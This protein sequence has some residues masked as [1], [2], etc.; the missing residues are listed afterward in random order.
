MISLS[1][2]AFVMFQVSQPPI[3]W[4]DEDA[5]YGLA[6]ALLMLF[7]LVVMIGFVI[8]LGIASH[9]GLLNKKILI[10]QNT[11][12]LDRVV[13]LSIG[14][15]GGLAAAI[16]ISYLLAGSSGGYILDVGIALAACAIFGV[17][18][19]YYARVWAFPVAIFS[20]VLATTA[21]IGSR[22]TRHILEEANML[23]DGGPWCL[24]VPLRNNQEPALSDL[25]FF[26]LPKGGYLP[27][28]MLV[29]QENGKETRMHWSIRQQRFIKNTMNFAVP[30]T[31]QT[32]LNGRYLGSKA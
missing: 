15:T 5:G 29:V 20:I 10:G 25:G 30:C 21:F 11:L 7:V 32:G 2:L 17:A 12:W 19:V 16:A 6:L 13:F 3:H 14:I 28:L 24:A 26:S 4:S 8:R 9:Y 31:P 22:Q 27:H 1:A 23:A 18:I